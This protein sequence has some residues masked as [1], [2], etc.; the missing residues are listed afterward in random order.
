[1]LLD[2]SKAALTDL[3]RIH[4][5]GLH[6]FGQK[7]A[8]D[9]AYELFDTMELIATQPNLAHE[10]PEILEG[11]RVHPHKSH[12]ILYRVLSDRVLILRIFF[13]RQNWQ[14]HI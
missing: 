7:V 5:S 9:Y 1:M 4:E 11:L 13:A 6:R 2:V 8:D 12:L 14:D 3:E 10:R